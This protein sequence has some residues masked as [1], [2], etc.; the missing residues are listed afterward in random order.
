MLGPLANGI[1]AV[2]SLILGMLQILVLA[3]IIASWIGDPNHQIVAM[4]RSMTEPLY[5]PIRRLTRG[6]PGPFDWAPM[7]LMLVIVF[8][9]RGVLP[10]IKMLGGSPLPG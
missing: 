8:V 7:I 9:D 10:Y 6:L 3:S 1:H 5:R 2:L 4:I